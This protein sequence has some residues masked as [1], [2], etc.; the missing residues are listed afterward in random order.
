MDK[1]SN[2]DASVFYLDFSL[3][4]YLQRI[5]QTHK[6]TTQNI[7]LMCWEQPASCR[8]PIPAAIPQTSLQGEEDTQLWSRETHGRVGE[9]TNAANH[10]ITSTLLNYCPSPPHVLTWIFLHQM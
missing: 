2:Y 8:S 7:S 5:L 9:T 1:E 4:D 10:I 3:M 6:P